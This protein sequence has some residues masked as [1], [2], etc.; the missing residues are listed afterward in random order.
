M[1]YSV[2]LQ[3]YAQRVYIPNTT[4][5][6]RIRLVATTAQN[7]PKEVFRYLQVAPQ[8]GAV[9]PVGEFSGVCSPLE[10]SQLPVAAPDPTAAIPWFRA[11]SVE[12]DFISRAAALETLNRI[13]AEVRNLAKT[14]RV[15]DDLVALSPI[16][17]S[18]GD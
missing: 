2:S 15:A 9:A 10:L 3:P 4:D 14:M 18:S 12:L 16:V 1:E 17:V 5:V 11:A 7:M 8:L 13:T 6:F